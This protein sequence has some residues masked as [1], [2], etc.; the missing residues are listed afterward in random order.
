MDQILSLALTRARAADLTSFQQMNDLPVT[1]QLDAATRKALKSYL[2]GYR[3]VKLKKGDSFWR[4]G[5]RYSTDPNAIAEANPRLDPRQLPIGGQVTVP[6]AFPLVPVNVPMTAELSQLILQ[7]LAARYPSI[8]LS[9]ITETAYGRP[10]QLVRIG[11]GPRK[12]LYTAAHHAN[13]WLTA[14]VMLAFLEELARQEAEDGNLGGVRVKELLKNTTLYMVPMVNPDGVDL[15]T[16]AVAPGNPQYEKARGIALNYPSIPFPWGWKANLMGVDLN[17]NYPALWEEA[18]KI[19][20]SQGYITPAPRDY[21]GM[22]PLDQPETK[23]LANLTRRLNPDLVLA[24]HS[25]GEVIYWKFLDQEVPG[26]QALGEEFARLSGYSLEDTP[27]ASSFAGFKDWFIQDFRK[28]GYT[29]EVGKGTNPLP[30]SQFPVIF[31]DNLGILLRG[32]TGLVPMAGEKP[33]TKENFMGKIW[34]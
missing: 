22:A 5:Q 7:G 6:M 15:V 30:T 4:L 33:G 20:F 13:E 23:A 27:Y 28:P 1:G 26:A 9:T 12:V 25:Q 11:R 19:K 10:V 32:M 17:L 34:E 8:S 21:V 29:I 2:L 24:Y 18:K 3:T 16:G 14:T 31:R